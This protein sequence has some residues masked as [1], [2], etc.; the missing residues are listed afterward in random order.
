M[1]PVKQIG[2]YEIPI[3]SVITVKQRTGLLSKIWPGYDVTLT[4]GK[5]LRFTEEEKQALDQARAEHEMVMQVYGMCLSA[6]L[7]P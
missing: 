7:R 5:T 2:R 1:N 6:G 3:L 4:N